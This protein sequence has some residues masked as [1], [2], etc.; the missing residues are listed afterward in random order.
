MPQNEGFEMN[1]KTDIGYIPLYPATTTHQVMGWKIGM[2]YG[3]YVLTLPANKWAYNK[4]IVSLEDVS[5][6]D[7]VICSQVLTGRRDDKLVQDQA[8]ALIT[9][10]MSLD[11]SVEFTCS[12]PP[13]IDIQ[14]QI[15]W[16]R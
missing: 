7:I 13:D 15:S 4:Q 2:V 14:V 12:T 8:Y 3:P 5:S 16:T 11:S 10:V 9:G 6:E 1:V